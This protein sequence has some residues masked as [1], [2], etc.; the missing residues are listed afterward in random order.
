MMKKL[1]KLGSALM[2][3]VA[4][5]PIA[6]ILMGLGYLLCPAF[7]MGDAWA[8]SLGYAT[9]GFAHTVGYL[10]I[11]AG[12]ALIGAMAQLFVIGVA[13]LVIFQRPADTDKFGWPL[14]AA[15]MIEQVVALLAPTEDPLCQR[16]KI[17]GT[18]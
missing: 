12:N 9:S 16:V 14:L 10:M 11:T 5:L 15:V 7:M 2:L 18:V 1:Q 4:V 13:S 6:G 3:P 8:E 17:D